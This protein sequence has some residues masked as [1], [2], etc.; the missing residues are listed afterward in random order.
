MRAHQAL[1]R[2][3]ACRTPRR[4]APSR[5]PLS[6]RSQAENCDWS[7]WKIADC[8]RASGQQFVLSR[9]E[10][11]GVAMHPLRLAPLPSGQVGKDST[12]F[13]AKADE[14][15]ARDTLLKSWDPADDRVKPN[16]ISRWRFLS[17][18]VKEGENTFAA[19]DYLFELLGADLS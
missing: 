10:L 5:W 18:K 8:S 12:R 15:I 7:H 4:K 3:R 13:Q 11:A 16:E 9:V 6:H 19:E 17:A 2:R 1:H 14:A